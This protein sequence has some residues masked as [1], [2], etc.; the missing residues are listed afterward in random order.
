LE[1]TGIWMADGWG[2][3]TPEAGKL[4][5]PRVRLEKRSRKER[6]LEGQASNRAVEFQRKGEGVGVALCT[7][8]VIHHFVTAAPPRAYHSNLIFPEHSP[9]RAIV[10]ST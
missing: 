3:D 8:Q 4:F 2:R 6:Y 1:I 5:P 10:P 9:K 7:P